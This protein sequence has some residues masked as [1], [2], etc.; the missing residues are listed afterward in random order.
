MREKYVIRAVAQDIVALLES[1][2]ELQC[3]GPRKPVAVPTHNMDTDFFKTCNVFFW[4]NPG[5]KL[6]PAHAVIDITIIVAIAIAI[7]IIIIIITKHY[8][9]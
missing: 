1:S 2:I 9:L 7:I 3:S 8:L 5:D 6:L 4:Y